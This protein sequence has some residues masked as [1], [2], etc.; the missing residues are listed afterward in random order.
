MNYKLYKIW[1]A[2]S[3]RFDGEV[4]YNLCKRTDKSKFVRYWKHQSDIR[5]LTLRLF[6]ELDKSN[7][8]YACNISLRFSQELRFWV[9]ISDENIA[10]IANNTAWLQRNGLTVAILNT[11]DFKK[12][13]FEKQPKQYIMDLI[14]ED[15]E[16]YSEATFYI[17]KK[18]NILPH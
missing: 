9:R 14:R 16:R 8:V 2:I 12:L 10:H 4:L 18:N 11:D 3:T 17:F 1:N 5:K 15:L 6:K 13:C 7:T